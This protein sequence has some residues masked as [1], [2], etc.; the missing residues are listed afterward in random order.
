MTDDSDTIAPLDDTLS[1]GGDWHRA[2]DEEDLM[3]SA[4][5]LDLSTL[6]S[7]GEL[8]R[9]CNMKRETDSDIRHQTRPG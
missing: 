4:S 8:A 7:N 1:H 9:V 6:P 2:S 3:S 5:E